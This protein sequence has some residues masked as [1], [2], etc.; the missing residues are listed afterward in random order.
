MTVIY[1][2]EWL[3]EGGVQSQC[4]SLWDTNGRMAEAN[5]DIERF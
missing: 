2:L 3:Q 4:R 1:S 5:E